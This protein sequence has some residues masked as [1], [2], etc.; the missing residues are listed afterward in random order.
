MSSGRPRQLFRPGNTAVE[1]LSPEHRELVAGPNS[2]TIHVID[3]AKA[4]KSG[5]GA[6]GEKSKSPSVSPG[7]EQPTERVEIEA[8]RQAQKYGTPVAVAL[9]GDYD[10]VPFK[11]PRKFIVLGWF[12]VVD[13]WVSQDVTMCRNIG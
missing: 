2:P 8:L 12:W 13:A 7:Q 11:V 10:G 5:D 3:A 4:L 9:A 6:I 1:A